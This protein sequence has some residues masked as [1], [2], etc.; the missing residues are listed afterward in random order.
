M[1]ST[2]VPA[3]VDGGVDVHF[4]EG[5]HKL[6]K[7]FEH[8]SV[9]GQHDLREFEQDDAEKKIERRMVKFLEQTVRINVTTQAVWRKMRRGPTF[10]LSPLP[11]GEFEKSIKDK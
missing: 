10:F 3:I 1:A 6:K 9:G 2:R 8:P 7:D 4:V 5:W 11:R